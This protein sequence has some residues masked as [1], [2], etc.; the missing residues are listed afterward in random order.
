VNLFG[1]VAPWVFVVL[2]STGF[3]VARYATNDAGPLTFLAIR[4]AI[5]AVILVVIGRAIRAPRMAREALVPAALA[6]LGI[7]AV[8][9]GG[10][11]IAID[12]GLPSGLGALIAGLHPV[13]TSLFGRV[14][15]RERLMPLQWLG[16]ALGFFGVVAVVVEKMG[17]ET[18]A[19]PPGALV[20]M[21]CAVVGM[22]G[23]TLIQRA[24]GKEMPLLSGTATQYVAAGAAFVIVAI[25]REGFAFT[26]TTQFVLALAWATFVLSLAAVLIMMKLLATQTAAGVSSLFFLTPALST[27]EGAILFGERVGLLALG[28]LVIAGVGVWLTMRQ[29]T[30]P[31]VSLID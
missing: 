11:F 18:V 14:L 2:W 10:V 24:S 31:P 26:L 13:V 25:P 8:Y 30:K 4:T 3:I 27:V 20:A 16:V 6:G 5:A 22:S 23:G 1:R 17:D 15:L 29:G 21:G 7:H 19:I 28:G 9:L 12:M